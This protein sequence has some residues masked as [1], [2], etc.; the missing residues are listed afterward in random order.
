[1]AGRIRPLCFDNQVVLFIDV[2]SCYCEVNSS[3]HERKLSEL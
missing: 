3:R 1:M 2:V